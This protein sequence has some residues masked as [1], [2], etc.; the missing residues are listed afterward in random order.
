METTKKIFNIVLIW[1]S[2]VAVLLIG[3]YAYHIINDNGLYTNSSSTYVASYVDPQTGEDVNPFSLNYYQNYNNTGKEV[4]EWRING[5]SDQNMTALYGRGYQLIIDSKNGNELYFCDTYNGMSWQSMHKYDEQTDNGQYK[6]SYFVSINN[7]LYAIRLDGT[8]KVTKHYTDSKKVA[9]TVF[10]LGINLL[11][12]DTNYTI[13]ETT[14]HYYTIED[15]MLKF[16]NMI[17][18]NSNGTGDFV[19]P[20]VDLGDYIHVYEVDEEGTV[21]DEPIGVG[22]QINSYFSLDIHYDKRGLTYA[23]QSM[24]DSVAG[25]TDFNIT[26]IDFDVNYWESSVIFNIDEDEF[27]SRYSSVDN[28]Y[29]Y[30]LS[31][32]LISELKNYSELEIYIVF[33][34]DDF[35][36]INVLGFDYYALNGIE[37]AG[38]TITSSTQRDFTLLAGALKDTGLTSIT[39]NNVNIINLSGTGVA[40]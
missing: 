39:A 13:T 38:L 10:C 28:G 2:F 20:V 14:T 1:C 37:V 9:R 25:D 18:S 22:G 11:F 23:E 30:A 32:D 40:A 29:Y 31:S 5:Y 26:G 3:V 19:L 33:N 17:K 6:N 16:A 35:K 7:E 24:F 12:E 34:I 4:L 21:S 15:I 36:N 8:Y 27:V